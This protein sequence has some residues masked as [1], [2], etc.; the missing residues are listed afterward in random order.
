M[1]ASGEM[2]GHYSI[3]H[4]ILILTILLQVGAGVEVV[5]VGDV[6]EVVE[7]E[8]RNS[9]HGGTTTPGYRSAFFYGVMYI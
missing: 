3:T 8:A 6:E 5:E 1:G 9:S 2:V 4:S 7:A